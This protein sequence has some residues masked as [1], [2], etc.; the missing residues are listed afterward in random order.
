MTRHEEIM[1][2][3]GRDPD[4]VADML[5][6]WETEISKVMPSDYKDW[7]ENSKDEWPVVARLTIENLREREQMAWDILEKQK[8]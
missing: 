7:W 6:S 5:V 1:E 4:I 2:M 3:M 8:T